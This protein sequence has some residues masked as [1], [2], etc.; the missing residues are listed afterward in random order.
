MKGRHSE[1]NYNKE[2]FSRAREMGSTWLMLFVLP[3]IAFFKA[4]SNFHIPQYRKF[5]VIFGLFYGATFIPINDS[6]GD[7]YGQSF[8][9][10]ENYSFSQY[11]YNIA[12]MYDANSRYPDV[13]TYSL[14]YFLG[15][16]S[17]NS[18]LFHAITALVYFLF[19][20]TLLGSVF[21]E[22]RKTGRQPILWFFIGLVFLINLS[23][24]IN[25]IRWPLALMVFLLGSFKL[26]TK[27]DYR[28]LLLAGLS[29][30]IHFAIM[31]AFIFLVIYYFTVRF[32]KPVYVYAFL[33]L[34][35]LSTTLFSGFIQEYA[36]FFGK[37]YEEK[38]LSYSVNE[39]YKA[40][41]EAH[42]ERWNWYVQI[43]R[44]STYYFSIV[45]LIVIAVVKHKI[46][47]NQTATQMEYFTLLMLSAS[48]I[49]GELVDTI[50]NRYYLIANG[51]TMIFLYYLSAL[52]YKN[53]V[54]RR[55]AN[56]YIP[57][58]ILNIL[59]ILRGDLY[60]ISPLLVIG[61]PILSLFVQSEVSIQT[62]L[63]GQ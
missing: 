14:F 27:N 38:V 10:Q 23:A 63:L 6:D 54:L 45:A 26:L 51:S 30:F 9:Q 62:L 28:F 2:H 3:I 29:V 7:R 19:F 56:V 39:L 59:I 5:I 57:F 33:A 52:N 58:L 25:G 44:F 53:I 15:L 8:E 47:F 24:G 40:N 22:A 37:V 13:Y 20:I 61:N 12:H 41:R 11:T 36:G 50:S 49:S 42:L 48:I 21:D 35:L 34:A 43:N 32:Y 60:T 17:K 31:Y 16:L 46:R 4:V 55:L 18:L 1:G